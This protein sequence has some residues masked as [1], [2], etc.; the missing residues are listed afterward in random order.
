MAGSASAGSRTRMIFDWGA[1]LWMMLSTR[2]NHR[3]VP[4]AGRTSGFC[5]LMKPPMATPS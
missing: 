2:L 1:W 5:P 4:N 3:V